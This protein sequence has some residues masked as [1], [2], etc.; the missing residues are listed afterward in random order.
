MFDI[1]FEELDFRKFFR[2]TAI[3]CG[4]PQ[5]GI[6]T[7]ILFNIYASDKPFAVCTTYAC[8]WLCSQQWLH[9]DLVIALKKL[10]LQLNLISEWYTKWQIKC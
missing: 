2:I 4:V 3:N 5:G 6:L 7:P 8:Y 1:V 10:Q 9:N